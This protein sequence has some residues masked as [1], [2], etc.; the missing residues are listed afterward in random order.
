MYNACTQAQ[1]SRTWCYPFV[2]CAEL[3]TLLMTLFFLY[4]LYYINVR[5]MY[6]PGFLF[7]IYFYLILF[8]YIFMLICLAGHSICWYQLDGLQC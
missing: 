1:Y 2:I 5:I 3:V 4:V 6:Y 8:I 7:Y